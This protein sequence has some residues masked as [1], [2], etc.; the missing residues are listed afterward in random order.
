MGDQ[1][2]DSQVHALDT[3]GRALKIPVIECQHDCAAGIRIKDTRKAVLHAPI[4]GIGTFQEKWF[5]LGRC[6]QAKFLTFFDVVNIR[7]APSS[8]T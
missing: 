3:G 1:G 6:I 2:R 5:I 7:H 4:Q 8:F